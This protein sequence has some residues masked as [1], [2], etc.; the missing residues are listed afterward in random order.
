MSPKWGLEQENLQCRSDAPRKLP[1]IIKPH[2][3]P[4]DVR[5]QVAR[6]RGPE[7][8]K[9]S[10]YRIDHGLAERNGVCRIPGPQGCSRG[11][12]MWPQDEHNGRAEQHAWTEPIIPKEVLRLGRALTLGVLRSGR[13]F[14]DGRK[15]QVWLGEG[16][17]RFSVNGPIMP[18][19]LRIREN[20]VRG[21]R[22]T[23]SSQRGVL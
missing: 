13:V 17:D 11:A 15:S 14:Q 7:L 23:I 12:G 22:R 3:R 5:Q 9:L 19:N 20:S 21:M 10:G 4:M 18:T 1:P 8:D 2:T 16:A 6:R